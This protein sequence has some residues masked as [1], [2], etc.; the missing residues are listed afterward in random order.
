MSQPQLTDEQKKALETL[1]SVPKTETKSIESGHGIEAE[2]ALKKKVEKLKAL[3]YSP[4]YSG[5]PIRIY[6]CQ[7]FGGNFPIAIDYIDLPLYAE[8]AQYRREKQFIIDPRNIAFHS[9]REKRSFI[10]YDAKKNLPL[11]V[12]I[13]ATGNYQPNNKSADL[14]AIFGVKD[15]FRQFIAGIRQE[16]ASNRRQTII[17]AI[18]FMASGFLLGHFI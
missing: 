11:N 12:D 17:M 3:G 7:D 9:H 4:T 15:N 2:N 16:I 14:F 13:M 10:F 8:S 5:K 18:V 6:L 1:D